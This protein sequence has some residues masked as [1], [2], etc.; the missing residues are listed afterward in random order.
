MDAL[1]PP[2]DSLDISVQNGLADIDTLFG[3]FLDISLP[4]NFWDPV[5]IETQGQTN[6]PR[7]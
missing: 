1:Q 7:S 2:V 4:T 5:F 6:D 3:E